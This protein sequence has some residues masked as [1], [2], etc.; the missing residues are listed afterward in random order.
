MD[1]PT[2]VKLQGRWFL[3]GEEMCIDCG[4]T[5]T[6]TLPKEVFLFW[7]GLCPDCDPALI[8]D[9]DRDQIKR[10]RFYDEGIL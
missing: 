4:T 2:P 1:T 10:L 5:F 9:L 6:F 7:S 8:F 3:T